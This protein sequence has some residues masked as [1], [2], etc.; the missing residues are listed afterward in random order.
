[1]AIYKADVLKKEHMEELLII[2]V[3][4]LSRLLPHPANM[5][6]VGGIAL[7]S[8]AKFETKK[9]IFL[10]LSTMFF[11]DLVI[12]FHSLMWATY[13]GMFLA[14]IVGTWIGKSP[15]VSRLLGGVFLSSVIFFIITNFAVWVATPLYPKTVSGLI[16]CYVMALP[17]FRNS[18]AGDLVYTVVFYYGFT[19]AVS[20]IKHIVYYKKTYARSA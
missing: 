17:F 20:F 13:G 8:G 7:F 11:S 4:V 5:T 12:G 16:D 2:T 15:R 1:M 18:I 6:A 3:G 10:T 14:V 9:A 19:S